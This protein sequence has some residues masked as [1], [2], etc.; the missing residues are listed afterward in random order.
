MVDAGMLAEKIAQRLFTGPDNH[1]YKY[2]RQTNSD[3]SM[4]GYSMAWDYAVTLIR[5]TIK[6]EEA[7]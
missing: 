3:L 6:A 1:V 4:A 2:L 7:T 5:D